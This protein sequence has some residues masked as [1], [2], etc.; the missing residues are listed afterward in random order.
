VIDYEINDTGASFQFEQTE[1]VARLA[2]AFSEILNESEGI[3][4]VSWTLRDP[5]GKEVVL[6]AIKPNGK[7]PAILRTE[8][9]RLLERWI[10]RTEPDG[11]EGETVKWLE[12]NPLPETPL[13]EAEPE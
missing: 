9:Q 4:Y 1:L 3:N 11:L 6:T 12:E 13:V 7:S 5:E 2:G 10:E 8:A